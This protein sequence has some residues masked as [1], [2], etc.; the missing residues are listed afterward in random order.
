VPS[1]PAC[2]RHREEPEERATAALARLGAARWALAGRGRHAGVGGLGRG[3]GG[4]RGVGP[5]DAGVHR[6]V[7]RGVGR[8]GWHVEH[9]LNGTKVV[10]CDLASDEMR[11]RIAASKFAAWPA[12]ASAARG[13]I[14]LQDHGDEVWYRSL[15]IRDLPVKAAETGR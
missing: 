10:D 7:G 15:R 3:I 14:A 4:P 9:W 5:R 13:L 2:K 8:R 11:Q 1:P 6:A 12:F